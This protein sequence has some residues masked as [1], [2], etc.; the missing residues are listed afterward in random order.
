MNQQSLKDQLQSI[1][2]YIKDRNDVIYL[3]YPLHLNVGDLLIY[4]GTENFFLEHGIKVKARRSHARYSIADIKNYVGKN[5]TILM[6]GGGNFGDLYPEY[7]KFREDVAKSFKNNAVVILPQTAYFSSEEEENKS[8]E[9]FRQHKNLVIFSRDTRSLEVFR[10]FTDK[11]YL[12]PDMAHSL[13][14]KL[15]RAE[16]NKGTLF[17]IRKDKEINQLQD[18]LVSKTTSTVDWEDILKSEDFRIRMLCRKLDGAGSVYKI[19]SLKRLSNW[20]WFNHTK[21]MVDRYALFFTSHEKVVTS[22]MHGH[23][24]SCL[25]EVPNGVIDNAYGKN[26]GYYNQWTNKISNAELLAE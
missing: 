1:L 23:I 18:K 14:G 2:A 26:S 8:A 12:M 13:W 15:P 21:K 16:K 11:S 3:D 5:T 19:T 10:K 24:F 20:I 22:R 6:H 4:H 17:L 9:I 25:L 7:Q